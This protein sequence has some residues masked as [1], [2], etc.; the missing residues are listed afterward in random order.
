MKKYLF[1]TNNQEI[2]AI[3]RDEESRLAQLEVNDAGEFDDGESMDVDEPDDVPPTPSTTA[4]EDGEVG[5]CC[6]LVVEWEFGFE[7]VF[8]PKDVFG[9][10]RPTIFA[11]LPLSLARVTS[12][13]DVT[14]GVASFEGTEFLFGDGRSLPVPINEV[15]VIKVLDL[16]PLCVG[17]LAY[18]M[19]LQGRANFG[20]CECLLCGLK[21]AQWQKEAT[22]GRLLCL[23][24]HMIVEEVL[25]ATAM[26]TAGSAEI[27]VPVPVDSALP[28]PGP[29]D[30]VNL[31][32]MM[33]DFDLPLPLYILLF[34]VILPSMQIE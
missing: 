12:V 27:E 32:D 7:F 29:A 9:P 26:P 20:E 28:T 23:E 1:A 10:E 30:I 14:S 8:M 33:N 34:C 15:V 25:A 3:L 6:V 16:T 18:T 17:D 24:D 21:K 4:A 5:K 19:L 2:E 31:V 22:L 11:E 13:D